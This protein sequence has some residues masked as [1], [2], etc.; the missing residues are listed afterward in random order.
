MNDAV[1]RP[2][3]I[4]SRRR[5]M[6]PERPARAESNRYRWAR[7][8]VSPP[9]RARVR[10]DRRTGRPCSTPGS[11]GGEAAR[12]TSPPARRT[13]TAWSG[14]RPR[15]RGRG[16]AVRKGVMGGQRK[17]IGAVTRRESAGPGE[18]T[19]TASGRPTSTIRPS[20]GSASASFSR[21]PAVGARHHGEPLLAQA[22]QNG[23]A[24]LVSPPRSGSWLGHSSRTMPTSGIRPIP[25]TVRKAAIVPAARPIRPAPP[26]TSRARSSWPAAGRT[27][28][29]GASLPGSVVQPAEPQIRR[30]AAARGAPAERR[31]RRLDEH[32]DVPQPGAERSDRGEPVRNATDGE[33]DEQRQPGGGQGDRAAAPPRYG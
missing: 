31:P 3:W 19:T 2:A 29:A 18:V 7:P 4:S 10:S 17:T 25:R 20:G 9:H 27:R 30:S 5:T 15:R 21:R 12:A 6:S 33:R 13:R 16:R 8:T 28:A 23:A 26:E 1:R 32:A 22:A 14:S 24:Q 11:C